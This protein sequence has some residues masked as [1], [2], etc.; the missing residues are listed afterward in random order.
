M[1]RNIYAD[2]I[3]QGDVQGTAAPATNNSLVRK[4]DVAGLS[5]IKSVNTTYLNVDGAGQL[6]AKNL[7]IS[8]V[9][10]NNSN[11]TASFISSAYSAGTE[12]Q[13]GDIVVLTGITPQK[14]Y[15]HNG[16]T[17]GTINDFTEIKT[18]GATY[19]AGSGITEGS[20]KFSLDLSNGLAF[21]GAG[22]SA[23][24][25]VKLKASNAGIKSDASGLY[26]QN[27]AGNH[28]LTMG[29]DTIEVKFSTAEGLEASANGLKVKGS[30]IRAKLSAPG[31]YISYDNS[32]GQISLNSAKIR[33]QSGAT[34]LAAN[35]ATTITHNLGERYVHVSAFNSTGAQIELEVV[36]TNTNALTVKSTDALSNV[37]I[38]CSI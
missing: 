35:T 38:V 15:I 7:L 26:L 2:S 10:S 12:F 19:T 1:A 31:N 25:K 16:G 29:A 21:D 30:Y 36:T 3:F 6:S 18:A 24:V 37:I 22:D 5:Y 11:S 34:N 9:S 28:T 14:T 20:N 27:P 4:S 8:D 32:N 23:K 33:F 17:A 13:K